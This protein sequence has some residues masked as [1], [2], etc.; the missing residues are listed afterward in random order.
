MLLSAVNENWQR[1]ELMHSLVYQYFDETEG[2]DFRN[3]IIKNENIFPYSLSK[4]KSMEKESILIGMVMAW[5]VVAIE[6]LVNHALAEKLD[7]RELAVKAINNPRK[8]LQAL[9]LGHVPD[10]KLGTKIMVLKKEYDNDII[11]LADKLSKIRNQ[12]IHDKPFDYFEN[13][14]E[15]TT[16]SYKASAEEESIIYRYEDLKDFF[17]SCDT[18]KEYIEKDIYIY[19]IEIRNFSS[20]I[21]SKL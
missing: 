19:S 8:V 21:N 6:S 4:V 18:I 3:R 15:V 14:G 1:V 7:T 20:L 16:K 13:D 17:I 11:D 10:S 5:A 9:Q 12:I 2:S